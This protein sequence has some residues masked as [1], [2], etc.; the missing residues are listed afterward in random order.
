MS[1]VKIEDIPLESKNGKVVETVIGPFGLTATKHEANS[2]GEGS[3]PCIELKIV[4]TLKSI[5]SAAT[6][7]FGGLLS[8]SGHLKLYMIP[9]HER[10]VLITA[11]TALTVEGG[12]LGGWELT[13]EEINDNWQARTKT[14]VPHMINHLSDVFETVYRNDISTLAHFIMREFYI[15]LV[16]ELDGAS[17]NP[18][19]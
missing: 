14:I 4:N 18:N 17:S 3:K 10:N 13:A 1:F 11:S 12:G 15:Q 7:L 6:G 9:D 19:T 2:I 5:D 16:E 8:S